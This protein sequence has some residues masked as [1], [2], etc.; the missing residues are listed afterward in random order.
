MKKQKGPLHTNWKINNGGESVTLSDLLLV[1]YDQAVF[2]N[3]GDD[4]AYARVPNGTGDFIQ[5][6]PT[7]NA[8]NQI[9]SATEDVTEQQIKL[10][11]NPMEG[12]LNIEVDPSLVHADYF[13]SDIT[14]RLLTHGILS[15]T[16]NTIDL[17]RLVSG[18]YFLTIR[19]KTPS[20]MKIV[21]L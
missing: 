7:F 20:T 15:S 4:T 8:N 3:Q 9:M 12:M 13:I 5:Q 10:Y 17:S 11:P 19:G 16:M 2:G 1:V 18:N 14:G 21:K 6:A